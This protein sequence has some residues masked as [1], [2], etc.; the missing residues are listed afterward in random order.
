MGRLTVPDFSIFERRIAFIDAA[1]KA[2]R[3]TGRDCEGL[4]SLRDAVLE[5]E[6]YNGLVDLLSRRYEIADWQRD[7]MK[8]AAIDSACLLVVDKK[9]G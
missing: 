8:A 9:M 1:I 2:R 5:A 4:E 6:G 7:Q 3:A